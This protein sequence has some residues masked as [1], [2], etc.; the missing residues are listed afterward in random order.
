MVSEKFRFI[1]I[2]K[3]R[4]INEKPVNIVLRNGYS[5]LEKL[6]LLEEYF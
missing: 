4:N 1:S 3:V 6:F 2:G 5:F